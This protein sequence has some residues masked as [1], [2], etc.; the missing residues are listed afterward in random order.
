MRPS[1]PAGGGGGGGRVPSHDGEVLV[2][3]LG[4]EKVNHF[5]SHQL[6]GLLVPRQ[7][8]RRE[9]TLPCRCAPLLDASEVMHLRNLPNMFAVITMSADFT[10]QRNRIILQCH[11]VIEAQFRCTTR[12]VCLCSTVHVTHKRHVSEAAARSSYTFGCVHR[13]KA[14]RSPQTPRGAWLGAATRGQSVLYR[15]RSAKQHVRSAP[16]SMTTS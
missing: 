4:A 9:C 14:A 6:L 1:L 10:N 12:R 15:L 5:Q 3:H 11:G 2:V 8:H 7:H 16:R 13:T